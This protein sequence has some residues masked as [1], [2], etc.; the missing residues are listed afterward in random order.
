[1]QIQSKIKKI[2][3]KI[4]A[5]A[6]KSGRNASDVTLIAVSKRKPSDMI[7]EAIDAGH[8]D[9]GENYIQEAME[10][11]DILGRESATW[12]F[13]GHLQSN[14]AKF[15]VKYFDL[16]HTVDKVKLAKEINRQAEKIGKTQDILLQVNIARETTKSG[17]R[18]NEIVEIAKQVSQFDN[19]HVS[20]LMCMPPFF[21]DPEEARDYFKQLKQLS[22]DID[23]LNL[24]HTDMTHLSMGMSNDFAVA[25]E[26]GATLVRVGTAIFGAR[27]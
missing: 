8:R 22:K 6:Q 4:F 15:A 18:E 20:G 19:L 25:V 13:I 11:I 21:D 16:I 10:K 24:P 5:A 12:H 3:D 26:E 23:R 17:A 14:K 2:H 9:F 1:M 7:Q 27:L